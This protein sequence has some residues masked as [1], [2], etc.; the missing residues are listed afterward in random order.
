[1]YN[2]QNA[3][4][5][6]ELGNN[7]SP[8]IFSRNMKMPTTSNEDVALGEQ[9]IMDTNAHHQ[10]HT[11]AR[12][13]TQ[14]TY[15]P[16][17]QEGC[18]SSS[19]VILTERP[20]NLTSSSELW[21]TYEMFNTVGAELNGS[22]IASMPRV[23]TEHTT[24]NDKYKKVIAEQSGQ[25][26]TL[27][28]IS[29]TH[30]KENDELRIQIRRLENENTKL[31]R[32]DNIAEDTFNIQTFVCALLLILLFWVFLSSRGSCAIKEAVQTVVASQ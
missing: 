8:S 19:P 10:A 30:A 17:S 4:A 6:S 15:S 29:N 31:K 25:M 2:Q 26:V 14:E 11:M 23:E 7:L 3:Y 28:D 12:Y 13:T 18:I 9:M 24:P 1:M 27:I 21:P 5:E 22:N 16:S 32:K 20:M